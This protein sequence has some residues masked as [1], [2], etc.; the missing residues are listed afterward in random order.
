MLTFNAFVSDARPKMSYAFSISLNLKSSEYVSYVA[1]M[2][3]HIEAYH[4]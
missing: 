1:V 2:M 3:F 4:V